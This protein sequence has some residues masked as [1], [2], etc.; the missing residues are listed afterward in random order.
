MLGDD[1]PGFR[2]W[3]RQSGIICLMLHPL[4]ESIALHQL[5]YTAYLAGRADGLGTV[6]D[7]VERLKTDWIRRH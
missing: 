5:I 2:E 6:S 3:L 4:I 7:A 1:D